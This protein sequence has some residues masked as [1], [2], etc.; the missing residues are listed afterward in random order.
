MKYLL[1]CLFL[2]SPICF[3][4][5]QHLIPGDLRKADGVL[6][7]Y[8][9]NLLPLLHTGFKNSIVQYTK[10]PSFSIEQAFSCQTEGNKK[11]IMSN[12]LSESYWYTENN[13]KIKLKTNSKEISDELFTALKSL[14]N[15]VSSQI[16]PLEKEI[17]VTDGEIY[18]FEMPQESGKS[19]VGKTW[20]PGENLSMGKLIK[21]S[22]DLFSLGNGQ[23]ISEESLINEIKLLI[24]ELT[25]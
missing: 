14:F 17:Y 2:I 15:L 11:V 10:I 23:K 25:K 21:I 6:H 4:Q 9:E 20:S 1:Y 7:D 8:Y 22:K 24:S 19:I 12:T 16:K 13:K 5:T 18:Y 3:A